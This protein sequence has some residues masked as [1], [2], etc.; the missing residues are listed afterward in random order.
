MAERRIDQLVLALE[1]VD[2][3]KEVRDLNAKEADELSVR[4]WLER[5]A[6]ARR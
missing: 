4:A 1:D 6:L 3:H 2:L 5:V